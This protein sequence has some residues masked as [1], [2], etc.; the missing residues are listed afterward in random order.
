MADYSFE[1]LNDKDL[2]NL[3]RDLLQAELEIT[4]E[5]FKSGKDGGIDLRYA[6]AEDASGE[7]VV[8]VKHWHTTGLTKLLKH[9]DNK[10]SIKVKALSPD[11]YILA[12]SVGLS[13]KNKQDIASY[14]HPFIKDLSDIYGKDD[15]NN[16]LQIHKGIE[17]D[18]YKLWIS[19][20]EVLQR[21]LHNAV[22]SR[23]SFVESE[24]I[25]KASLFVPTVSLEYA[26]QIL[27]RTHV[28]LLKGVPGVGKTTLA[29]FL[30]FQLLAQ[31]FKL[32]VVENDLKDA[33]EIF[34]SDSQQ[35]FY[36]DD[37]LGSNYLQLLHSKGSGADISR[38][39]DR[40]T[41]DKKKRLILTTRT[42]ILNR[43]YQQLDH[44]GEPK[45]GRSDVELHLDDYSRYDR[46]RILYNH[47]FFQEL[48]PEFANQIFND[49]NYLKIIDHENYN[50][51]VIDFITDPHRLE[52]IEPNNYLHFI[53][54]TLDR[55]SEIWESA[56][57]NQIDADARYALDTLFSLGDRIGEKHF[58][59]A[60]DARLDY[61]VRNHGH[62]RN[63]NVFRR[64]VR[65]L[66]DG[67]IT[68]RKSYGEE[69][70]YSFINPSVVDFLISRFNTDPSDKWR[71]LNASVYLRQL[72]HRFG[73]EKNK[74][75]RIEK[76]ERDQYLRLYEDK[77]TTMLGGQNQ[78]IKL[79]TIEQL[80]ISFNWKKIADSCEK[81]FDD[82]EFTG[83]THAAFEIAYRVI[84]AFAKKSRGRR[85]LQKR[86]EA[87]FCGM[88][89]AAKSPNEV[90]EV[91]TEL[92]LQ[93]FDYDAWLKVESN[94]DLIQKT[95]D[96]IWEYEWQSF[97]YDCPKVQEAMDA[98]SVETALYEL[99]EEA[100]TLNTDISLDDSPAFDEFD[101]IDVNEI[102]ENNRDAITHDDYERA[103]RDPTL[104]A[105]GVKEGALIRAL[106][107][108]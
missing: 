19:S 69:G 63:S 44:L 78:S 50:P 3:V 27:N 108:R 15:L 51:R 2:E 74:P 49:E 79:H 106:F 77:I 60:F 25:R 12:T 92:D 10:E 43:A 99:L 53:Q 14:F 67:F 103:Q 29:D 105:N 7:I 104:I 11:R 87:I 22:V 39:V 95:L 8:Q 88:I 20:T 4:L 13:K 90:F 46:A 52:S 93:D 107:D 55:P 89:R 1:V 70:V 64:S 102:V 33:E 59:E 94:R 45:L 21:I 37:F 23:S 16:L 72:H 17:T 35:L 101:T 68:H 65:L 24:I 83:L 97:I 71:I 100:R 28:L 47:M 62:Y 66:L 38:F 42:T 98:D 58:R 41:R 56:Y 9:L 81:L 48:Q 18:H 80:L 40:V 75:I 91:V 61:E 57:E 30:A 5:T 34:D 73:T 31:G 36:F 85:I 82:I 32:I 26:H 76:V 84:A 54:Q 6:R 96:T 86:G